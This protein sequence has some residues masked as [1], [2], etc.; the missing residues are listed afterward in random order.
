ML[1]PLF[2]LFVPKC[3]LVNSEQSWAT[4]RR[5]HSFSSLP[6]KFL[7]RTQKPNLLNAIG[8]VDDEQLQHRNQWRKPEI[9]G[10]H[11]E[12][13][14]DLHPVSLPPLLSRYCTL[15]LIPGHAHL[16]VPSVPS[17][18]ST[19]LLCCLSACWRGHAQ[20][21][22]LRAVTWRVSV[23]VCALGE[24]PER[25]RDYSDTI[26]PAI[27]WEALSLGCRG[28]ASGAA[29]G[30]CWSDQAKKLPAFVR[31][32]PTSSVPVDSRD[33]FPLHGEEGDVQ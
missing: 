10:T 33:V 29:L 32:C 28:R 4:L 8:F 30:C 11:L 17:R 19:L 23:K 31:L 21:E 13:H 2:S 22:M 1:Y 7:M 15:R 25:V 9:S 16:F 20:P 3:T 24:K 12:K 5:P 26:C 27:R 18:G 6:P 14:P